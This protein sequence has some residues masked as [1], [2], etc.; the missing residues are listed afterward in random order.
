MKRVAYK[1][2]KPSCNV[3]NYA[4]GVFDAAGGLHLSPV[5]AYLCLKPDHFCYDTTDKKPEQGSLL[6]GAG[7]NI[8][9]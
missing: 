1:S 2:F 7:Q 8:L 6:T 9:G 3:S 4:L 5:S